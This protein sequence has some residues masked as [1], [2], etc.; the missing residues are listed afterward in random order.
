MNIKA[1]IQALGIEGAPVFDVNDTV[2]S[3][4]DQIS[5]SIIRAED[6]GG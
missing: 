4:E 3:R 6:S 5:C 1:Q 2:I